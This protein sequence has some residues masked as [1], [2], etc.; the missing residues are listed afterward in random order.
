MTKSPLTPRKTVAV[1][2]LHRGDN[3]QPGAA[4]IRSLRRKYPDIRIIGLS[5]DPLESCLYSHRTDQLDA[6]YSMPFPA[7]GYEALKQRLNTILTTESIDMI[8]PC[9][10][11]E[12]ENFISLE[13][14]FE[15]NGIAVTLPSR[16]AVKLR[17]KPELAV[18][19]KENHFGCPVT[20]SAFDVTSL[21]K[22]AEEINYP[23]YIK[24]K[25]YEG[26][27][28]NNPTELAY[29]AEEL[30]N[31]WGGPILAQQAIVG[32]EYCYTGIG[33]GHGNVTD[34]CSI[35]KMLVTKSGKGFAGVVISDP[36][37]DTLVERIINSL[38]WNGPF[39]M[40]FIKP[41]KG[42][43]MLIEINPR[44]PAWIDF[45]SQLG[46]NMPAALFEHG[47]SKKYLKQ[48][49]CQ[50]GKMF[51]RHSVDLLGDIADLAAMATTGV[52]NFDTEI[53]KSEML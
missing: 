17:S 53:S 32:E 7:H 37:L 51:I 10:D 31:M 50:P 19:C 5:Y 33:D 16:S 35:R 47:I 43:H 11:S 30:L 46:C 21:I 52:R 36:D 14:Y 3:P 42:R 45:P 49:V 6:A 4:V 13:D 25:Y 12:I 15:Q 44:F 9:L 28:V 40:E 22:A 23:L 2:G 18:F 29:V 34:F 38:K 26:R 20:H 24:G 27:L 41:P 39:E 1:T 48:P 8:I